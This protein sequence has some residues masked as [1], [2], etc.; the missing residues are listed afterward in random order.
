MS[1]WSSAKIPSNSAVVAWSLGNRK[2]ARKFA[3]EAFALFRRANRCIR[4]KPEPGA[5]RTYRKDDREL[6]VEARRLEA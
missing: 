4:A 6:L 1:I 3:K 5:R 2:L